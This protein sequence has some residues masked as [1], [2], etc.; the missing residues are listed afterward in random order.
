MLHEG[1]DRWRHKARDLFEHAPE[2]IHP[3]HWIIAAILLAS[4]APA[5]WLLFVR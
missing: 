1:P 5:I 3:E 2:R 4:F